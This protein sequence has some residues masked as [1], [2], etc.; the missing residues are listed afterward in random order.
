MI[1]MMG[2]NVTG[3]HMSALCPGGAGQSCGQMNGMGWESGVPGYISVQ[4][5]LTDGMSIQELLLVYILMNGMYH[6][7]IGGWML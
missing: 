1:V 2:G 5:D 4:K 6:K 7:V 3:G